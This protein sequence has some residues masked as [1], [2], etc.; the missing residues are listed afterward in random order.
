VIRALQSIVEDNFGDSPRCYE[1]P[2]M[3]LQER[4]NDNKEV[5]LVFLN[6]NFSHVAS[7]RK[8]S[9][10][11]FTTED[12][13]SFA[14]EMLE[15]LRS[16]SNHCILDGIVRVD[17]FKSNSGH[18]VVNEFES[19]DALYTGTSESCTNN[20]DLFLN[21]YWEGKI[22]NSICALLSE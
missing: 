6:G 18:L 7:A 5:K 4:V 16:S 3:M 10:P 17:I 8:C 9:L 11:G 2:Y 14:K 1:L 19:L 20:T 22:Y 21:L 13:V 12:L 15:L